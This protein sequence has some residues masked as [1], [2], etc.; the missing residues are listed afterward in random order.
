MYC[1][2]LQYT[3]SVWFYLH[4]LLVQTHKHDVSAPWVK[5]QNILLIPKCGLPVYCGFKITRICK[6]AWLAVSLFRIFL[7]ITVG[8]SCSLSQCLD[9]HGQI[10]TLNVS[11]SKSK[12]SFTIVLDTFYFM[13]SGIPW[14]H[15]P[16]W[17]NNINHVKY[18]N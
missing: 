6:V 3:P 2:Y 12:I 18:Y 7:V 8:G 15:F 9:L 5:L 11:G 4:T 14:S 17:H 1:I 10:K 13:L 16:P